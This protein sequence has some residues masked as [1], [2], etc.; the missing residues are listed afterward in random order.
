MYDV[1]VK[2]FTFAIS[3]VDECLV[4][5]SRKQNWVWPDLFDDKFS[6]QWAA[7][8]ATVI[9]YSVRW[10]VCN[11]QIRLIRYQHPVLAQ[12]RKGSSEGSR[13]RSTFA[14]PWWSIDVQSLHEYWLVLKI[15][16]MLQTCS[17]PVNCLTEQAHV[18]TTSHENLQHDV[19]LFKVVP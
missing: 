19:Q 9:K 17:D 2:K 15:N 14:R 18:V 13:G 8:R 1:V 10:T 11:K 16:G 3:S 7:H 12:L 6:E 4:K 5:H